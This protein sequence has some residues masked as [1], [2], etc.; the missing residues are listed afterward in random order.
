MRNALAR[1]MFLEVS[2]WDGV[3]WKHQG[4]V[5]GVGPELPKRQVVRLD[6]SEVRGETVRVRLASAPSVWLIDRVALDAGPER[7]FA[8][9][10]IGLS[11][12]RDSRGRDVRPQ[13]DRA[14]GQVLVMESE[15]VV[16]LRFAVDP[17]PPGRARSY[18][19]ATTG[20]YH[21]HTPDSA[22]PNW[23]LAD[24]L[25]REPGA[26]SRLSAARLNEALHTMA[27]AGH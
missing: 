17:T 18:L 3:R 6:L 19:A 24:R 23:A 15:D 11:D 25:I 7:G 10:E 9:K 1:E 16:D 2:V 20:W 4:F 22:D 14:D 12:A 26:M 13:L 5:P 27:A 21:L 8:A